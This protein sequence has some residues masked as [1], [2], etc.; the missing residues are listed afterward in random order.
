MENISG[1][2]TMSNIV[3]AVSNT[4]WNLEKI[5]INSIGKRK[6]PKYL[7][8]KISMINS[9]DIIEIDILDIF[10]GKKD[11]AKNSKIISK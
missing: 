5:N 11:I 3:I 7:K 8:C 4:S 1:S 2:A 10:F 9:I 6:Y